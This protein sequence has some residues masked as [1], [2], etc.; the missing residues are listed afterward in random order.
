MTSSLSR[1]TASSMRR[2]TATVYMET[3]LRKESYML[4]RPLR[5]VP[6]QKQLQSFP[7]S[8]EITPLDK[9]TTS[10]LSWI[11]THPTTSWWRPWPSP[12][13]LRTSLV[14][15]ALTKGRSGDTQA[16][17]R[18]QLYEAAGWAAECDWTSKTNR[19][20]WWWCWRR[21]AGIGWSNAYHWWVGRAQAAAGQWTASRW[22]WGCLGDVWTFS[23]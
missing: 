18:S 23:E 17:P 7:K 8:V 14:S 5:H 21:T 22:Q 16:K 1:P 20:W 19:T 12:S 13:F 4:L 9:T 6:W 11:W 15:S 10:L 2:S 3:I